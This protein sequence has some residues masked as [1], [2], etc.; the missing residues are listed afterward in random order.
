MTRVV[1]SI[2]VLFVAAA[3]AAEQPA[4]KVSLRHLLDHPTKFVGKRVDVTGYCHTSNEEI[5]LAPTKR[6][7]EQRRGCES[8]IWL[9]VFT[10]KPKNAAKDEDLSFKT[11]RVIGTFRYQPNPI[12]DKSVPYERRFRGFGSYKMWA[13]EIGNITYLQPVR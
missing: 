4:T 12:L 10:S 6:A 8:S 5:S 2:S 1:T 7:D 13:C 9:D 3:V 11:V